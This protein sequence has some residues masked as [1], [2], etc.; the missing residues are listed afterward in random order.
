MSSNVFPLVS[1]TNRHTNKA[2]STQMRP[3]KPYVNQWPK[4]GSPLVCILNIGTNDALTIQL[5][6]HWNA[7]A[8]A[9]AAPRMVMFQATMF[10][11]NSTDANMFWMFLGY[12][13][14]ML[15]EIPAK[16]SEKVQVQV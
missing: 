12:L 6:I 15:K 10:Y 11:Q 2:A 4:L 1:G 8:I 13:V 7:T 16:N 9:V 3:Y 14:F 5:N